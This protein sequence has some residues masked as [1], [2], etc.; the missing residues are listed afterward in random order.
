MTQEQLDQIGE[1]ADDCDNFAHAAQ[2]PMPPQF[3]VEQLTRG[4]EHV[5][6][7]LRALYVEASGDNPWEGQ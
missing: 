4:F 1:I 5:R 6:D 3:H 2:L 7:L